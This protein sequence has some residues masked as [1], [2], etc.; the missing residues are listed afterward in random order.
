MKSAP[1]SSQIFQLIWTKD[2]INS[3]FLNSL[4]CTNQE[5]IKNPPCKHF[6]LSLKDW[7]LD[8]VEPSQAK[9][10]K[11]STSKP[12][13]SEVSAEDSEIPSKKQKCNDKKKSRR[14]TRK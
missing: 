3:L 11:R 4:S 1:K 14:S 6:S 12:S 13:G 10:R 7:C 5:C 8:A 2:N 9:N